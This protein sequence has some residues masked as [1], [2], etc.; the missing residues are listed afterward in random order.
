MF[1]SIDRA[2]NVSKKVGHRKGM[3]RGLS[4][5]GDRGG[6][7][8]GRCKTPENF[9]FMK[10]SKTVISIKIRKFSRFRMTKRTSLLESSLEI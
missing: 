5:S 4:I 6:N 1:S 10:K 3:I 9:N 7:L 8:G 2:F